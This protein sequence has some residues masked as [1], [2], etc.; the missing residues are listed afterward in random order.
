MLEFKCNIFLFKSCSPSHQ[1]MPLT[2]FSTSDSSK[3]GYMAYEKRKSLA[4]SVGK[5]NL[6]ALMPK[7]VVC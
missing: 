7:K 2:L 1:E 5:G 6:I 4:C 3:C